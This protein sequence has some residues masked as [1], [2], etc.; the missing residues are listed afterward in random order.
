MFLFLKFIKNI[1]KLSAVRKVLETLLFLALGSFET[2]GSKLSHGTSKKV[3][4]VRHHLR[5]ASKE[6]FVFNP[7]L[8]CQPQPSS[9]L[10][11]ITDV[12]ATEVFLAEFGKGSILLKLFDT[13]INKGLEFLTL[14]II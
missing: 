7:Q 2:L 10:F 3:A 4:D 1:E 13:L 11:Q 8:R 14:L 12:I 5:K 9:V 6:S